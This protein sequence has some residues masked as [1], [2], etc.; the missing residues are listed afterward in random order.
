[1]ARSCQRFINCATKNASLATTRLVAAV[2]GCAT[3][4]AHAQASALVALQRAEVVCVAGDAL[5]S[6]LPGAQDLAHCLLAASRGML[7]PR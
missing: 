6:R 4:G 5:L 3:A 2:E 7:V 1:M